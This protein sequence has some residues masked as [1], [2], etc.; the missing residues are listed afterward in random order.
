MCRELEKKSELNGHVV[1]SV[2]YYDVKC[3][4][5][6]ACRVSEHRQNVSIAFLSIDFEITID[7]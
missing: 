5:R 3:T 2:A 7:T 1:E 6:N 4:S